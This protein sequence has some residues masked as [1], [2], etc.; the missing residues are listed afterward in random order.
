MFLT[1][2]GITYEEALKKINT[3]PIR[4]KKIKRA[5]EDSLGYYLAENIK[6]TFSLPAFR[7]SGYDGYGILKED[8]GPFPKTFTLAEEVGAGFVGQKTLQKGEI[9]RI[10]T[11][12]H[13]P[14]EV[15]K[16]IMLENTT[17]EG[18][19]VTIQQGS[20]K[21]NIIP[22]GAEFTEGELLA[23]AGTKINAGMISLLSAF[24]NEDVFVF[25]KPKVAILTT[26]SEL[27]T[28]GE[29][30]E[31]GKI[32]NSN[33][34]LL[35]ALVKENGGDVVITETI[36]DNLEKTRQQI[37]E[38][39]KKVDVI[40]TTGGVSVGDY[41][42]MAV[43]AKES[44][45]LLFNKLKMRPGSPTTVYLEKDVPVF[46]LSGNPGAC[47]TGFYLFVEGYLKRLQGGV[48][49]LTYQQKTLLSDYNKT[50]GFD[51]YLRGV[52]DQTEVDFIGS[53]Q[54]S[55]LGNLPQ[56]TCF[57]KVP[58]DKTLTKGDKVD[59]WILPYK[60]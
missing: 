5:V 23:T 54:S 35:K 2:T 7:R 57:I 51:K 55:A 15:A 9:V 33:G 43:L 16:V 49:E 50:N 25:E 47:F 17:K 59:V 53:D 3:L 10:M 22:V 18:Q 32:Y 1:R 31:K 26:G 21:D 39:S 60:S 37:K 19:L 24:G 52:H 30:Y 56:T 48:R 6:A 42:F 38:I 36:E 29:A 34:P 20:N 45:Q 27:L 44:Q 58:H 12:A 11:G 4:R 41:D 14:D 28:P 8:D 13:V 46:A 40:V